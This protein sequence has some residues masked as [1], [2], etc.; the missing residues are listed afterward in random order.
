MEE[1]KAV[2]DFEAA[3]VDP[4]EKYWEAFGV[5]NGIVAGRRQGG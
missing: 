4:L 1:G 3:P 2:V 5:M